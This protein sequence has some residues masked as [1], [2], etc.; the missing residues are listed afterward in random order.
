M[1]AYPG[2]GTGDK[3]NW[4]TVADNRAARRALERASQLR[5]GAIVTRTLE[6]RVSFC[7]A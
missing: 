3:V 4:A 7:A 1:Q 6:G 5:Q 2:V